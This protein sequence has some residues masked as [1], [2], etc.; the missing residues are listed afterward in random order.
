[1]PRYTVRATRLGFWGDGR[2]RP[3]DPEPFVVIAA[4]PKALGSWM[5]VVSEEPTEEEA[6]A[7]VAEKA[8]AEKAAAE[9]AAADEAAKKAAEDAAK[10]D[11]KK[12]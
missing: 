5:K 10:K 6:A 2:K 12:K 4:S 7:A 9:K 11:E 8:A 3:D 1:M